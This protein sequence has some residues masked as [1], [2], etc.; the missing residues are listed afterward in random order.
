MRSSVYFLT[1]FSMSGEAMLPTVIKI[2]SAASARRELEAMKKATEH[3]KH[4]AMIVKDFNE[5]GSIGVLQL[6]ISGRALTLQQTCT[7]QILQYRIESKPLL[8]R[9][10]AITLAWYSGSMPSVRNVSQQ[11]VKCLRRISATLSSE[12]NH[13]P[14]CKLTVCGPEQ[15]GIE[16]RDY[17]LR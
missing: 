12:C 8:N 6:E 10:P 4:F 11:T 5:N 17:E 13:I 9:Q 1:P 7:A 16:A 2:K 14:T 15:P 3:Y